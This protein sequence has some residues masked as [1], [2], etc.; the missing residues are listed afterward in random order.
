MTIKI[1]VPS[2]YCVDG[3]DIRF[4]V[5][6]IEVD[7]EKTEEPAKARLQAH[8]NFVARLLE[9]LLMHPIE[10]KRD[11]KLAHGHH[12]REMREL[13]DKLSKD[14]SGDPATPLKVYNFANL[15][16]GAFAQDVSEL[17]SIN[18]KLQDMCDD[19]REKTNE[20]NNL[21]T[22]VEAML[23]DVKDEKDTERKIEVKE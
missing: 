2:T 23:A 12:I 9:N 17:E 22:K 4:R 15:L 16:E 13:A 14:N 8:V 21:I 19:L 7:C 3:A 11:G 10:Y 1:Q 20:T 5:T 6:K 18:K